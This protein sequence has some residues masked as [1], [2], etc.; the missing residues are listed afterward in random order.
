MGSLY[1]RGNVWWIKY[2][3]NGKCYRKSSGSTK[4][5]V[6]KKF[7]NRKEGDIAKGE[8]Y[9]IDFSKVIFDDLAADFL[10]DYEI[11]ENKSLDRAKQSLTHLMVE[12]EGAKVIDI[13]TQRIQSIYIQDR[14]K[15]VQL[16]CARYHGLKEKEAF[17]NGLVARRSGPE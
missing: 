15:W 2:Y 3:R 8:F 1:K 7:L 11:N 16:I 6:A 5:M 4:K 12:F 9:E 13:T 10:M 14:K 17:A